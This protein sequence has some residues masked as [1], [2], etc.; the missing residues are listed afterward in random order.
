[1][2][3]YHGTTM[4]IEKPDVQHSKKNLDFGQGFYVTTIKKQAEKWAKRKA[5]RT[6]TKAMINVYEMRQDYNGL[7]TMVFKNTDKEWLEFVCNC[8]KGKDEYKK[9]DII[10]GNVADDD[11]FKT[12]DMYFKGFW[13][14]ERTIKELKYYKNN[15]QITFITEKAIKQLLIFK[16][17]YE[18]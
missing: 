17:C 12:I 11:V 4:K 6:N 8:R 15:D 9:Y 10:I 16:E 14:I 5:M 2:L 3:V 18:V 13:D 1:M 7:Q